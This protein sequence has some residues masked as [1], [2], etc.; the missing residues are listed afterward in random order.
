MKSKRYTTLLEENRIY[1][2]DNQTDSL[3]FLF[4]YKNSYDINN[5]IRIMCYFEE[6]FNREYDLYV[7]E[8]FNYCYD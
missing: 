3:L 7:L 1:I 5:L 4:P 8:I 2:K 6:E